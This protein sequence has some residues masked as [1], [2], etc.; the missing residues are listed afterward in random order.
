MLKCN[1][2]SFLVC[3][4]PFVG[5]YGLVGFNGLI[6]KYILFQIKSKQFSNISNNSIDGSL[7]PDNERMVENV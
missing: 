1:N 7:I 4:G 5:N 3:V 2:K 6:N